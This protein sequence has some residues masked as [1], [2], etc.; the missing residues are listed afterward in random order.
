M[1]YL[2]LEAQVVYMDIGNIKELDVKEAIRNCGTEEVFINL[3]G[4]YCRLID[5]KADKIEQCLAENMIKDYV[6]EV[7]AMKS[8]SRLIGAM[9]LCGLFYHLE[10]LGKENDTERLKRDTAEIIR[11][12]RSY[13]EI[14]KQYISDEE[15]K[16]EAST[17][18][19]VRCLQ[20]IHDAIEAFD[21]D[22]ADEVMKRLDSFSV[23]GELAAQMET[24]HMY[25]SDVAMEE[26]LEFT[27]KMIR[28]LA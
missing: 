10:H 22:E 14:L 5:W 15:K 25:L 4:D 11:Y 2:F 1:L 21:L 13:K 7:H 17:D 9:D 12:F 3:L 16:E 20:K 27:E 24:L 8:N 23:S 26:I 28:Q 6:T 18:E 19:I